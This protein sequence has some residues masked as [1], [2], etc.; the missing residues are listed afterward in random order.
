MSRIAGLYRPIDPRPADDRALVARA[1]ARYPGTAVICEGAQGVL[2]RTAQSGLASVGGII[3]EAGLCVAFDG[4]ITN[5]SELRADLRSVGPADAALVAVLVRRFGVVGALERLS[6]DFAIA[7]LDP[8]R[9]RLWLCRDRFGVKPLYWTATANGIAFASQPRSL[10]TIPGVSADPDP[11]FVARFAASHYRTFDSEPEASPY[12]AIHQMPAATVLEFRAGGACS[13]KRYWQLQ[14]RGDFRQPERELA[15]IY[16]AHMLRVLSRVDSVKR[17][18]FTLSGGLDSSS[19]LSTQVERSGERQPAISCV[20]GDAT[21]DEREQIRDVVDA[22]VSQWHP[23]EIGDVI[24]VAAIVARQVRLHDE[25]VA[26]ATWLSHLLLVERAASLGGGALIGGLG[27]DELNAGEYEYFPMHFADLRAAGDEA[28]LA[29]EI[30][31]WSSHHDHPVYRKD[32]AAAEASMARLTDPNQPGLCRP[33]RDRLLR[34]AKVLRRD[35]YDLET[36]APQMDRP[37][38]SY[39]KNRAYQD[40]FRETLPCCLRAQDRHCVALDL[41]SVNPF[42]DHELAEFMFQVPGSLKIRDG[43]T[44][45]L[46]RVAMTGILPEPTRT[47]IAKTGWNAPAHVWFSERNL[48]QLRDRVQSTAFRDR[49]I[50][51]PAAVL[52]VIEDHA[53]IVKTGAATENHMM[54]LWQLINLD[55]WLEAIDD[56]RGE[57]TEPR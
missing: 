47:R 35:Y 57:T 7:I 5:A 38:A 40:M 42:L 44:K 13:S 25:P 34:Y 17:P 28:A 41:E 33:D 22:K 29:H 15:E 6:G 53:R 20:Y 2:G 10:L 54:F 21:Y 16:R 55:S 43:I 30:V 4:R 52:A 23:V 45:R 48:D 51:D 26:T 37:F 49:G 24:D 8:E 19:M 9:G 18:L 56:I 11:G 12:R 32:A 36:F 3:E 31:C 27:G 46:L 50:Y 14:D 1:L 39:L